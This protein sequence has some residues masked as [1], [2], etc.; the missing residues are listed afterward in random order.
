ML[1]HELEE[2]PDNKPIR[3]RNVI[4][5][6]C[7]VAITK[8]TKTREHVIGSNFVPK[9]TLKDQWN[10]ILNACRSC[11]GRKADLEDDISA[12]SMQPDMRGQYYSPHPQLAVDATHKA[13]R[14]YSRYSRKPVA[15]SNPRMTLQHEFAPGVT[16]TFNMVGQPQIAEDRAFELAYRHFQAFF[17]LITYNHE[18]KRGWYWPGEFAP[19]QTIARNDWGNDV[20]RAFMQVTRHWQTRVVAITASQFFKL[21]IR[22]HP[23][24]KM[25]SL[26]VEWNENYR[27]IAVCGEEGSLRQFLSGL[28]KLRLDSLSETPDSFVRARTE[29]ALKIKDD[30]LFDAGQCDGTDPAEA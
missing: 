3:L 25:W 16:M 20:V 10:L 4:C 18:E 19:I 2:L 9:G 30:T 27:V 7:G 22:K 24:E 17:F 1:S 15:E 5:P 13:E 26:A 11:N 23:N 28:P 12:I 29:Q 6:Y 21:G 14:T 8:E